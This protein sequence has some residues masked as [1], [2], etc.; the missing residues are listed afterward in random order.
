MARAGH[1]AALAVLALAACG[2]A[3]RATATGAP[4]RTAALAHWTIAVHVT[5]PVDLTDQARTDGRLTLAAAG[6]LFLFAP[7]AG[8]TRFAPGYSTRLGLE[9]YIAA[10]ATVRL[11]TAGCSFTR[12]S[13]YALQPSGLPGVIRIDA[14]GRP[15]RFAALP[16]GGLPDGITFDEVGRFG[17]RLLVTEE[18]GPSRA[19]V[20]AFDCR[21]HRTTVTGKAPRLE[22]GIA[23]APATFGIYAG[24]LVAANEYNGRLIDI[25]AAGRAGVL[26]SSGL[27]AG[28]DIGVETVG[29]VPAG[30]AAYVADRVTPHHHYAGDNAILEL[31][32]AALRAAGVRAGDLLAVT[33]GGG[34]TDDVRCGATCTVREVAVGTPEA[35]I[36]GHV[37]FAP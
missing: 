24:R 35:Y 15:S 27:P 9:P 12:D 2:T 18:F 6:R 32:A 37:A 17:H 20:Y 26:A 10:P 28:G 29:F 16:A 31:S 11:P 14:A 1:L 3:S 22:G 4:A 8:V 34:L 33:E 21:G 30:A 19:A 25:D 5:Q 36:E 13:V 7:P 23:V